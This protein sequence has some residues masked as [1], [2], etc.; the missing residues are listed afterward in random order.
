MVMNSYTLTHL[1]IWCEL[2][3]VDLKQ[4]S[5]ISQ[6]VNH[7]TVDVQLTSDITVTLVLV[8][9]ELSAIISGSHTD[10][11]VVNAYVPQIRVY[12]C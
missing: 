2:Y 1:I 9:V 7:R 4:P 3:R 5:S 8:P 6:V 10:K 12:L 11:Y